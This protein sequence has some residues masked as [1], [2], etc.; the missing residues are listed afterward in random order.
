MR[1]DEDYIRDVLDAIGK[2]EEFVEGMNYEEFLEDAKTRYAVVR[3]L[4]IIGEAVKKI[5]RELKSRHP[6][7][8]WKAMAGMRDKLIHA[9]FGVDW[10]AVWLTIKKDVPKIKSVFE[11]L[12]KGVSGDV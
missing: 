10:E 6:E 11:N 2:I 8:P 7:I 9:Y 12:L 1:T 5:S 3:A 4:E